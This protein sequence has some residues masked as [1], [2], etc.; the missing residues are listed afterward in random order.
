MLAS[1][2]FLNP[3]VGKHELT[4]LLPGTVDQINNMLK[5]LAVKHWTLGYRHS[6]FAMKM[7]QTLASSLPPLL[8]CEH[9]KAQ[10]RCLEVE[11][12]PDHRSV[13]CPKLAP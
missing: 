8:T 7:A 2:E 6:V 5:L 3:S 13:S 10:R 12:E 11:R 9:M 1:R 4:I